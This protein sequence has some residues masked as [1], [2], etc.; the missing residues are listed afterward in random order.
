MKT[1][2]DHL[3]K[4][5]TGR[6]PL[7]FYVFLSL[8]VVLSAAI[9][10]AY[11]IAGHYRLQRGDEVDTANAAIFDTLHK[12]QSAFDSLVR[13]EKE[14]TLLGEERISTFAATAVLVSLRTAFASGEY[15]R[16]ASLSADLTNLIGSAREDDKKLSEDYTNKIADLEK[17]RDDYKKQ[18]VNVATVSAEIASAS[19]ELAQKS[20]ELL[21]TRFLLISNSLE[22]LLA[23]KKE[24]D[25]KAVAVAAAS[26]A[27]SA[28]LAPVAPQSAGGVTYERKTINTTIGAFSADMLT[29]DLNRIKVKTFTASSSDCAS[30][31]PLKPLAAYVA[32]NGGIA[33]ING[34]YFCPADYPSCSS[35][36]NAFDLLVFDYRSKHYSNSAQN[37]YSVNPLMS[38][39]G[40][41]AHFYTQALGFGRDTSA[42]G[43]ISNFPTLIHNGG[44]AVNGGLDAK[45]SGTKSTRGGLGFNGKTLWAVMTRGATVPDTAYV[46]KA[47]GAQFAMNLDGGGSS[48]LY[49]GGYKV[50]P[51]RQLPNAIVFTN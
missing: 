26:R 9:F 50:G 40:D 13:V 27:A 25:K 31:C 18:G 35:K 6:F 38:F 7:H 3:K 21:P 29:V 1:H 51:G 15:E 43:A 22:S 12:H 30:N 4:A 8:I 39:Y 42:Y 5:G 24:A 32:E 36:V 45:S 28:I 2:S 47:L 37:Q 14:L 19:A 49:F 46:F 20:Y 48:A 34:S 10:P 23:Q 17:K 11:I 44:V 41:G 33:G 16:A